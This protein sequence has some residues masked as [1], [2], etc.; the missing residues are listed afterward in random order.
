MLEVQNLHAGYKKVPALHGVTLNVERGEIVSILGANGAGKSTTLR[1]ISGLLRPTSGS[2]S[3][4]GKN[5]VD[6][7]SHQIVNLGLLHVPEGRQ[8]FRDM[9]VLDHLEISYIASRRNS[10]SM[11]EAKNGVFSLFPKLRERVR[12]H[13]G[14][15]SGGEQ[16]MLA[17]ARG[18]MCDPQLLMLDEPSLGLAPVIVD[19]VAETILALRGRGITIL[20]VE[21]NVRLALELSD[22]GYVLEQGEVVLQ[23]S[24]KKLLNDSRVRNTYLGISEG[25]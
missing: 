24:A 21:Q 1:A 12:Q 18:L 16:Q 13:A 2:V 19:I 23:D 10:L 14:S 20:L 5:L 15:L 17:I 8:I 22:R 11:E 7:P 3:F 9:T 25:K 6:T 4:L